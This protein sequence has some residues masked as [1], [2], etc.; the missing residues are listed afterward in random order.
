MTA[1]PGLEPIAATQMNAAYFFFLPENGRISCPLHIIISA[2]S[3]YQKALPE[4]GNTGVI[5]KITAGDF[6]RITIH[7]VHPPY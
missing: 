6:T 2:F 1:F 3:P 7:A 5:L 4:A